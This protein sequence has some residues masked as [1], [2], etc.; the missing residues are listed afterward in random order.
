MCGKKWRED[1]IT[2]TMVRSNEKK[3]KWTRMIVEE[4]KDMNKKRVVI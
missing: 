2:T 1:L 4:K 3:E